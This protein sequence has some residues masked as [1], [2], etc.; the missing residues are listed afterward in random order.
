MLSCLRGILGAD[1]AVAFYPRFQLFFSPN[2]IDLQLGGVQ[3][4]PTI[5]RMSSRAVNP[6]D[7]SDVHSSL[8]WQRRRFDF[9]SLSA[10]APKG[11][12]CCRA[13]QE[14]SRQMT[15]VGVL[16]VANGSADLRANSQGTGFVVTVGSDHRIIV[17]LSAPVEGPMA[18]LRSEAAGLLSILQQVEERYN[19]HVQLMIFI[20]CLALLMLLCK[21]GQSDFWPD[22]GD[23]VHFDVL[24]RLITKKALT[25]VAESD[26]DQREKSR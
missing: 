5:W 8:S 15:H 4:L 16:A 6:A 14:D 23:M 26:S 22:P 2:V 13:G 3:S 11:L 24:F 1:L 19:G 25:M 9:N 7:P 20:E 10:N 12:S 21:W 18:L 17:E